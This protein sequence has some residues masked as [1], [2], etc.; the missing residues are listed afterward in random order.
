MCAYVGEMMEFQS[1]DPTRVTLRRCRKPVLSVQEC[2]G[3]Q[4]EFPLCASQD[5]QES[6][7][8]VDEWDPHNSM[9]VGK[10]WKVRFLYHP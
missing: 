1:T 9:Q 2:L 10:V 7:V 6:P 3:Q 8:G 4:F 5:P